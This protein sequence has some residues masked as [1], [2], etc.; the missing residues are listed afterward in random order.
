MAKETH[1]DG[2]PYSNP[3]APSTPTSDESVMPMGPGLN[4]WMNSNDPHEGRYSGFGHGEVEC[5][6]ANCPRCW[7]N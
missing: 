1:M 4:G 2:L 7:S 6:D 5:G 3:P